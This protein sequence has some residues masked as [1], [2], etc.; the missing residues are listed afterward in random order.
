MAK[1]TASAQIDYNKL[2]VGD[3]RQK[4]EERGLDSKGNKPDLVARLQA[5]DVASATTAVE[6]D[7]T[8]PATPAE[9][10]AAPTATATTPA[11]PAASPA[12]GKKAAA[13]PVATPAATTPTAATPATTPAPETT[14][15]PATIP[16]TTPTPTPASTSVPAETP[17][18]TTQEE[19]VE[20]DVDVTQL[21]DS[22][23]KKRRA[24]RFGIELNLT[25]DDKKKLRKER[26]GDVSETS[27][28]KKA[29]L[30][31]NPAAQR[32]GLPVRDP[33]L[34]SEDKI[35]ARNAKFGAPADKPAA[36][37]NKPKIQFSAEDEEKR[38]KRAERFATPGASV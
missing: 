14:P 17:T 26:F 24:E 3:L 31:Q 20:E 9:A 18:E 30:T 38:R 2:K 12:K 10:P 11:Q 8:T 7:T 32:L 23:R 36:G 19:Q 27:G 4:L 16:T 22:E 35:K 6:G 15:A 37:G 5:A 34:V 28:R 1:T 13:K 21:T 29:N 25:S 33:S